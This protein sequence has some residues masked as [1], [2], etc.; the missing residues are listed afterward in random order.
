ML[1]ISLEFMTEVY[2]GQLVLDLVVKVYSECFRET[3]ISTEI[4]LRQKIIL[5]LVD[6]FIFKKEKTC[7]DV[8]LLLPI[9]PNNL[10]DEVFLM[11]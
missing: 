7:F 9:S 4:F 2:C 5:F 3:R 1:T 6:E 8:S 10:E 11:V